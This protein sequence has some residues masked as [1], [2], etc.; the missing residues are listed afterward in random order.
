MMDGCKA[1]SGKGGSTHCVRLPPFTESIV[2]ILFFDY[3]L[4]RT[5]QFPLHD[6]HHHEPCNK[7][8]GDAP[9]MLQFPYFLP[10]SEPSSKNPGTTQCSHNRH[11]QRKNFIPP[12]SGQFGVVRLSGSYGCDTYRKILSVFYPMRLKM[13]MGCGIVFRKMQQQK[14]SGA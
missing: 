4:R 2:K 14:E 8:T 3:D 6:Q 10:P 12:A 11:N 1:R 9:Q 5:Q 13:G 7:K